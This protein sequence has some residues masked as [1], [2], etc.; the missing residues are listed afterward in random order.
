MST[1]AK[2]DHRSLPR[3]KRPPSAR[4]QAIY[5][6]RQTRGCSQQQL[7]ADNRLSQSRISQILRRVEQWRANLRP[8]AEGELDHAERQRLERWLERERQQAIYDR[9]IR[10]FDTAPR[11]LKTTK[12]GQRGGTDYRET[13]IREQPPGTPLLRVAQRAADALGKI[14]D[15]PPPPPV[16]CE[17]AERAER[18]RQMQLTLYTL[19][20]EAEAAGK[21]AKT[22]YDPQQNYDF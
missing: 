6:D 2:P 9:A 8:Q 15:K 14:A 13:T 17:E 5:L 11:E 22:Q 7:A 20:R 21:V 4:D 16:Q 18:H 3:Q 19:R 1:P 12:E 10:A